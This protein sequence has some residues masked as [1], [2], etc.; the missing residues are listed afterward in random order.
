[1]LAPRVSGHPARGAR[2]QSR[3]QD[4]SQGMQRPWSGQS[5]VQWHAQ[6][7]SLHVFILCSNIII[8][9]GGVPFFLC[10]VGAAFPAMALPPCFLGDPARWARLQW[11]GTVQGITF[12]MHGQAQMRVQRH[13]PGCAFDYICL[14]KGQ[15]LLF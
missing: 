15:F 6:R 3:V 4:M 8:F 1:M 14:I 5:W 11:L 9:L 13:A 2:L 7:F 12:G 10:G